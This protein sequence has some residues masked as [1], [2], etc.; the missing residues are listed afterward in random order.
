[1]NPVKKIVQFGCVAA[2]GMMTLVGCSS[3]KDRD[4]KTATSALINENKN[5]VAFGHIS[6]QSLLDKLD[7]KGLPMAGA[8]LSGELSSWEKAVDFSK[9]V[10]VAMQAPFAEDGSPELTYAILD[11][12]DKDS[13]IDKFN[14]MGYA[15]DKTGDID[16]F[17]NGDVT[18]GVRN[19]LAIVLIKG[20]DYDFK[21]LLAT[22]FSETEGDESEGKTAT[23]LDASG[24][25]VTGL[26]I[27]RLYTTSNTSLTKLDATKKK[28]LD[29]LTA[30]AFIQS[31][32]NF[33]NGKMTVKVS[34]LFSEELKDRLFFKEDGSASVL[35]KLGTGN[36]WMG[37]SLNL[38]IRKMESFIAEFAPDAEEKM[39]NAMPGEAMMAMAIM[40]EQPFGKMFSGQLGFVLTGDPKNS[41]GMLP[42]F[43]F[44]LGLGS[45]G[46]FINEKAIEYA[47]L[48]QMEKQ[49]DAFVTEGMAVAPR[50][51]GLYG[52][53]VPMSTS[54]VLKIPA[55]AKGFG[56]NT[57]SMF[58]NF[59]QIDVK[60][61]ELDDEMRV[62]EIMDTFVI[63]ADRDGGEMV[64]TTKNKSSNIL[65]QVGLF[66][67]K[68]FEEKMNGMSM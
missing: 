41:M 56:K 37:V 28:E 49:G 10:Y 21:A 47:T 8:I 32:T 13:L 61:L 57:F 7:Y 36:A 54:G 52:Y 19:N 60:S 9:P 1:M 18:I 5:I 62:L 53:T 45:K 51:D 50:K 68:I 31:V 24:D 6:V 14:S 43:N 4:A 17:N 42:Q 29:K 15:A 38:D 3:S 48:Q 65:K 64:I 59:G 39:N 46:D 11:V 25:I 26:N 58:I 30:D 12:K 67:A 27:E 16:C 44:F 33:E 40:G 2:L 22:A 66:Y 35:K 20:G 23:I 34:N 63:N 55:F